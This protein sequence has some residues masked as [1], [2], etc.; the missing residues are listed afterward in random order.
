MLNG[1]RIRPSEV[2]YIQK[3][4][5]LGYISDT[6]PCDSCLAIAKN[7]DLL[8][9]EST[10]ESGLDEKAFEYTHLTAKDAA[11]IAASAGAKKL[12][13][14]HFSQRYADITPILEEARIY[15]PNSACAHD[16]MKV[17]F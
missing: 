3:G 14:T 6:A 4:R 9:S 13:L 2:T 10:F 1:R 15:F 7:A 17:Q 16:F 5:V 8:I 12:I 11:S